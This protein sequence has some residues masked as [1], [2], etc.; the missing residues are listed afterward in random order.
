MARRGKTSAAAE[1]T[2]EAILENL[3]LFV[4]NMD[5]LDSMR[6]PQRAYAI[7]RQ[8]IR[9]LVLPP[10]KT[11]LEREVAETLEM[12]R[13]P[14][15]EALV[16]LENEGALQLIPRKGFYVEPIEKNDLSDI[17]QM[18]AALDGLAVELAAK[19]I[20]DEEIDKLEALVVRQEEVLA[21]REFR[22]WAKLDDEFHNK[23]IEFSTNDSLNKVL[24]IYSD[25]LYKAR[26]YTINH[27]PVPEMSIIEHKAM[28]A[29]LRTHDGKAARVVMESHRKRAQK[30]I[31]NALDEIND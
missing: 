30:E 3:K 14:V 13:T 7:I 1:L 4:N 24:D 6:F 17:Y 10:G 26:L 29:C 19:H 18:N 12:S 21:D 11:I 20:D 15:R 5:N 16:R 23:I 28:I 25:K 31:L 22:E 9:N 27:R 8:A 2:N